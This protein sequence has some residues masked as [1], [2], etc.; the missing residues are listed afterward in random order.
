[1]SILD[2]LYPKRCAGCPS[3][4]NY[5]C[6]KCQL[7]AKL[8]FPQVCPV[9]ERSSIDGITHS[10][11]KRRGNAPEGLFSIWVYEGVVRRL[12]GKLKYKFVS[13][14]ASD[15][16]DA[17]LK[18]QLPEYLKQ[19]FVVV[20]IPLHWSRQNWRGFN[21]TEELVKGIASKNG[22]RVVNLLKRTRPTKAQV[23]LREADREKNVFGIFAINPHYPLITGNQSLLLFDDVWTTGATML[24]A[25]R[26]LKKAGFK[27]VWCLTLAR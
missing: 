21:H 27:K 15:L 6:Q 16:V 23:G 4:G 1:M 7:G 2:F 5:F 10:L 14:A 18:I 11:C 12:I 25:S 9:C 3:A 19:D 20:P 8:Q 13:D 26:T 24:E 22:W 17:F